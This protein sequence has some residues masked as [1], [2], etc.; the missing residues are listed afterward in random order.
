MQRTL[1]T[2]LTVAALLCPL[3]SQHPAAAD[4][5]RGSRFEATER[6]HDIEVRVDRGHATLVVTRTLDN[7]GPRSDQVVLRVAL[8]DG[9]VATRLRTQGI[10][11][12]GAPIWYEGELLDAEVA[13]ARYKELTG[14]GLAVPK[15]P[16]LLSWINQHELNLQVFPV[17][18]RSTKVVE[19]TLTMPTT[20][21]DGR[22]T[23][24]LPKLG[25]DDVPATIRVT[26]P[27]GD[28]VTING[29]D[30]PRAV[31]SQP[32]SIAL[33]PRAQASVEGALASI[34]IQGDRH[35]VHARLDVAARLSEVPKS[36][37]LAIV[38]DT[39][40]SMETRIEATLSATRA[41]LAK[42]PG[43]SVELLTFDRVVRSP[44]G[45]PLPVKEMLA[46]LYGYAPKLENGSQLDDALAAADRSLA[47]RGEPNAR[48][49]LI[50]TDLLTREELTPERF[51]KRTLASGAIVH[52]A[53]VLEGGASLTRDDESDW[54]KVPR[55]SG[56]LLW[57][58]S[59]PARTTDN[60]RSVFEEWVRPKRIDHVEVRGLPQGF[61]VDD[62]LAEGASV[63]FFDFASAAVSQVSLSG[64]LWSSPIR[65]TT[66]ASA[67]EGQRWSGLVF[68]SDL[69]GDL[70]PAEQKALAMRGKVVSPVTSYL[71]IEPGVRPSTDGIDEAD[72]VGEG[73]GGFGTGIGLG[74]IGSISHCGGSSM[75]D[76]QKFL[77]KALG[78][79]LSACNVSATSTA[80]AIMEST[81]AEVAA[82]RNVVL[83]PRRDAKIEACVT[84]QLWGVVLPSMFDTSHSEWT[85]SAR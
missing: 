16:A 18:A 50:L 69:Y 12:K 5:L 78:A 66:S 38:L 85:L 59:A 39:S 4:W 41:F 84:E 46:R 47:T 25:T 76:N 82:V 42:F 61:Q 43:A 37:A 27:V 74:T 3:L 32:L 8:P 48:R 58:A 2:L 14:H 52:M 15:D 57:S 23:L 65:F 9:A 64:E 44:F 55:R 54:A 80:H 45:G 1:R 19:Y 73:G 22:Y 56:G 31:A 26:G 83:G 71:A 7:P 33:T 13:A 67:A 49:I 34:A 81:L 29:V 51:A 28:R 11:A 36:A 72:G 53:T 68:G 62:K 6:A 79:A 21:Q 60:D 70:T 63:A 75:F 77:D 10:D 40:R 30:A 17:P 35:M 20:Y 24:T